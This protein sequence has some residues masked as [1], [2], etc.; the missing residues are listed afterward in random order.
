MNSVIQSLRQ[1]LTWT[2]TPYPDESLR[3]ILRRSAVDNGLSTINVIL[4]EAG[5]ALN[6]EVF[7][8]GYSEEEEDRLAATLGFDRALLCINLQM[9]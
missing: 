8:R 6:R 2:V 5:I 7:L 1:K 3:S 9:S 4:A